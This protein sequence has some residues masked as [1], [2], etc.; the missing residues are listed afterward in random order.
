MSFGWSLSDIAFLARL[1]HKT[2]QGARAACGEYSELTRETSSLHVVLDR[3]HIEVAKPD[4]FMHRRSGTYGRELESISD[5]CGEVLGQLDKILVKYNALNEQSAL[6]E[7]ERSVRRLWK[8]IRFGNGAVVVVA[9]LRSRI[10]YYTSALSLFLNLIS[11]STVGDVEKKMDQADEDLK[12]IKVAVNSIAARLMTTSESHDGSIMTA[13]AND[14]RDAW[15]ELRRELLDEGILDS[16]VRKHKRTIMAYMRELGSR[17]VL[18]AVDV[19]VAEADITSIPDELDEPHSS[20]KMSSPTFTVKAPEVD[21][22]HVIPSSSRSEDAQLRSLSSHNPLKASES[23]IIPGNVVGVDYVV[24]KT[25]L[26]PSRQWKPSEALTDDIGSVIRPGRHEI[27]STCGISKLRERAQQNCI[28]E[29]VKSSC[30]PY[31]ESPSEEESI[32]ARSQSFSDPSSSSSHSVAGH[33]TPDMPAQHH[34]E[35]SSVRSQNDPRNVRAQSKSTL[36]SNYSGSEHDGISSSGVSDPLTPANLQIH[37]ITDFRITLAPLL[38]HRHVMYQPSRFIASESLIEDRGTKFPS[39]QFA[40]SALRE[41]PRFHSRILGLFGT[42][43]PSWDTFSR[44][45]QD[46]STTYEE[47]TLL[48]KYAEWAAEL[49]MAMNHFCY[50]SCGSH[51]IEARPNTFNPIDLNM[52]CTKVF[53]EL[54]PEE[55]TMPPQP[56]ALGDGQ[57]LFFLDTIREIREWNDAFDEACNGMVSHIGMNYGTGGMKHIL[58]QEWDSGYEGTPTPEH[59]INAQGLHAQVSP[60]QSFQPYASLIDFLASYYEMVLET[61][62]QMG[63]TSSDAFIDIEKHLYLLQLHRED[64]VSAGRC[65]NFDVA[66]ELAV[67]DTLY[68]AILALQKELRF[69][70]GHFWVQTAKRPTTDQNFI[71]R[72]CLTEALLVGGIALFERALRASQRR[73]L[74]PT[75]DWVQAAKQI[76]MASLNAVVT[77]PIY[78]IGSDYFPYMRGLE[79][80]SRRLFAVRISGE[81]T[82]MRPWPIFPVVRNNR[83]S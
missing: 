80:E 75:K 6:S 22:A 44:H 63:C 27:K 62:S 16:L 79:N 5:G 57:E 10:T 40:Q 35:P 7:Q 2:T 23:T 53:L 33:C 37:T 48:D 76:F 26:D 71:Y 54:W 31:V 39:S 64:R 15:R 70:F 9:E 55:G 36:E 42:G 30:Q 8:K 20:L 65:T 4:S 14:D 81:D 69:G 45:E 51:Y 19:H 32:L 24:G 43:L 72:G 50:L 12:D 52:L 25:Y 68:A 17:G 3:L 73:A 1:A 66:P 74:D 47:V 59:W 46:T 11:A 13:Y 78:R 82:I 60:N 61:P 41:I 38:R 29:P 18:D 21:V 34:H 56:K 49:V 28:R 77:P 67:I 83:L 58:V